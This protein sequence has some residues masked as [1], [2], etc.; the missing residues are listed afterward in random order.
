MEEKRA[1]WLAAG[2]KVARVTKTK[3]VPETSTAPPSSLAAVAMTSTISVP[4][5]RT[6]PRFNQASRQASQD[7]TTSP[8]A[9]EQAK[10][11]VQSPEGGMAN[12]S[13]VAVLKEQQQR[14]V[15]VTLGPQKKREAR[16]LEVWG[17]M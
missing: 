16:Q 7:K 2:G 1:Q 13:S 17:V 6:A 14:R 8:S 10:T 9:T 15:A 12:I 11:Q 5:S 4:S 3:S